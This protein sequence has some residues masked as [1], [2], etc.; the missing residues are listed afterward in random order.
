[1]ASNSLSSIAYRAGI[2]YNPTPA[3]EIVKAANKIL[4]KGYKRGRRNGMG[5][6]G[7]ATLTPEQVAYINS[8]SYGDRAEILERLEE[9]VNDA[10]SL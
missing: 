10:H 3:E 6:P 2:S 8:L 4:R 1:M 7:A 5:A 9:S